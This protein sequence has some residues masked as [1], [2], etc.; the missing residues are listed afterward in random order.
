MQVS[1][2][3]RAAAEKFLDA[4]P[5]ELQ[6]GGAVLSDADA[7]AVLGQQAAEKLKVLRVVVDDEE[8]L[9]EL[10]AKI[11]SERGYPV[12]QATSVEEAMEMLA[13][14]EDAEQEPVAERPETG[15][16]AEVT[17]VG[18]IGDFTF[19]VGPLAREMVQA[20]ETKVRS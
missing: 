7:V 12:D 9:L 8:Q 20:Y 4:R 10:I 17:P 18:Q 15:T 13:G 2:R 19:D 5:D 14:G 1:H 16:A 6:R 3:L 11:L